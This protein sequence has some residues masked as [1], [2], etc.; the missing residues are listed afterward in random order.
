MTTS[1]AR[2][3]ERLFYFFLFLLRSISCWFIYARIIIIVVVLKFSVMQPRELEQ[4]CAN[5]SGAP[6]HDH[7]FS[8]DVTKKLHA[9]VSLSQS[10]SIEM[11][12]EVYNNRRLSCEQ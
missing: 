12:E 4:R 5:T 1:K 8:D 2:I 7:Y 6:C 3:L 9:V 10:L 11:I